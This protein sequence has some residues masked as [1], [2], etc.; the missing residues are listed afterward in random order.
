MASASVILIL[1]LLSACGEK[2][3]LIC[4]LSP[5]EDGAKYE[6]YERLYKAEGCE[7]YEVR[8]KTKAVPIDH[9]HESKSGD[10][11]K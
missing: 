6:E 5:P 1:V 8:S 3:P 7:K 10:K 11:N 4:R 2:V 9:L